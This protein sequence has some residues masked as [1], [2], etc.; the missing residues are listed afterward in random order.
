M[1]NKCPKPECS[2]T[3]YLDEDVIK[4]TLCTFHVVEI[5]EYV[6]RE[7]KKRCLKSVALY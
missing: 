6:A 3:L 7:V 5:P 2:G 1:N 4:C